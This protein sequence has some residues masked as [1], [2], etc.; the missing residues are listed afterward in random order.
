MNISEKARKAALMGLLLAVAV[1]LSW[2]EQALPP[3]PFL[4]PNFRYGLGNIAVMYCFFSVGKGSA[5]TL[6]ALKSLFVALTRGPFAGVMS[7]CGGM[8]AILA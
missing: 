1:A 8:A 3:L 5:A 6:N 7:L 2:C 4:P